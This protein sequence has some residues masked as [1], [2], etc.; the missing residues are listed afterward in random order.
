MER[1]EFFFYLKL[2][3]YIHSLMSQ[4][5]FLFIYLFIWRESKGT[6]ESDGE[7]GTGSSKCEWLYVLHSYM[8]EHK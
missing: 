1:H 4:E 6:F 5:G 2:F 8:T 3:L 7:R